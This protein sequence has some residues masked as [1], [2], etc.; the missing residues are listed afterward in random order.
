MRITD[1]SCGP[2]PIRALKR[3]VVTAAFLNAEDVLSSLGGFAA[4][5]PDL[6]LSSYWDVLWSTFGADL[7][8]PSSLGANVTRWMLGLL[9][10]PSASHPI[11]TAPDLLLGR[12]LQLNASLAGIEGG[13]DSLAQ[14][15]DLAG[16]FAGRF[17][18]GVTAGVAHQL[19]LLRPLVVDAM[20]LLGGADA[21]GDGGRILDEYPR[22]ILFRS[23]PIPSHLPAKRTTSQPYLSPIPF[24]PDPIPLHP[25]SILIPSPSHLHL[26]PA[27]TPPHPRPT[28]PVPSVG[29]SLGI[30]KFELGLAI[31]NWRTPGPFKGE[32]SLT[33]PTSW[34][35]SAYTGYSY[36]VLPG[37]L[38]G[39]AWPIPSATLQLHVGSLRFLRETPI[40]LR[41]GVQEYALGG[42]PL[43]AG[44]NFAAVLILNRP[45]Q[46]ISP[47]TAAAA[48]FPPWGDGG[49]AEAQARFARAWDGV[50]V[51]LLPRE[52]PPTMRWSVGTRNLCFV[53]NSAENRS[54]DGTV[55]DIAGVADAMKRDFHAMMAAAAS[56]GADALLKRSVGCPATLAD[57]S[58][59][60]LDPRDPLGQAVANAIS[61]FEPHASLEI[62]VSAGSLED[63]WGTALINS[64]AGTV[65][66]AVV[67]V[68]K[69]LLNLFYIE[70]LT[71]RYPL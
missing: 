6:G 62:T 61:A 31:N 56:G 63:L 7:P 18:E 17:V 15:A 33:D 29:A 30:F 11:D 49:D 57:A 12:M 53:A 42:F 40:V 39:R 32:A 58:A 55:A 20:A 4:V 35:V 45:V 3:R 23:H 13:A 59:S 41:T 68:A 67:D 34:V 71:I 2:A 52:A 44:L 16:T 70:D 5:A 64:I 26:R 22:T 50:G 48:A 54:C 27:A 46:C 65:P 25:H 24:L 14:L 1:C 47:G 8:P 43:T 60:S 37:A 36:E 19:D 38:D 66:Q 9:L 69:T 28:H 10:P 21:G 51:S